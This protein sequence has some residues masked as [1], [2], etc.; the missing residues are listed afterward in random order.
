MVKTETPAKPA[1]LV[2]SGGGALGAAHIG[3]VERLVQQ[4]YYFDFFAG[5]S[6]GAIV[7]ALLASQMTAEE[8]WNLIKSTNFLGCHFDIRPGG[9]GLVRGKKIKDMLDNVFGE[10]RVEQTTC[11]LFIGATD[12]QSGENVVIESGRIADAVR[13]SISVPVVYSPFFHPE[14]NRWLVDGGLTENLPLSIA[15]ERYTGAQIFAVDVACDISQVGDFEKA[16]RMR[17]GLGE[18]LIRSIRI[19]LRSQQKG[20]PQD[21]RVRFIRPRLGDI[22]AVSIG[23]IDE[24]RNRGLDAVG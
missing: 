2:L 22:S 4:G 15:L 19:M 9:Y 3:V 6:A 1:A 16:P 5:V 20:L 10:Y 23:R 13:S 18:A 24:I 14:L 21:P 8:A 12:F 17:G 7:A 11:P